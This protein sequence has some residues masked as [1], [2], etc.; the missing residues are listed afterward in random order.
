MT[1]TSDELIVPAEF[2]QAFFASLAHRGIT[3]FDSDLDFNHERTLEID[4]ATAFAYLF[5]VPMNGVSRELNGVKCI[6]KDL[7][8]VIR[9]VRGLLGCTLR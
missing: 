7:L 9:K 4:A 1:A 8:E 6:E 5:A 3:Y 2:N